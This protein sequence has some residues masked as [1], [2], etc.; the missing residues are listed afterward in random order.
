MASNRITEYQVDPHWQFLQEHY[1][2]E[3]AFRFFGP[4]RGASIQPRILDDH[5]VLVQMP[6]V[7]DNTN[8][9]GTHFGGS[10]Y[11]MADPFFM[12]ILMWNLGA[13]YIV[14]DKSARIDFL[15][16][17]TGTV[18]ARFHIPPPEIEEVRRLITQHRKTLR[19]YTDEIVQADGT[20][21]A[22]IEKELYVRRKPGLKS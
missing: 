16:P 14:W 13:D 3:E 10:L 1:G 11:S 19:W 2:M 17:A 22:R 7:A 20:V 8:Y 18:E 9:V 12:F 6:Q 5:T 4:Y 21:V 15:K